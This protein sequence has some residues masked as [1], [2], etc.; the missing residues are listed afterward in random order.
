MLF[1]WSHPHLLLS[2]QPVKT[3]I[4]LC[5]NYFFTFHY[6]FT[7]YVAFS[8]QSSLFCLFLKHYI[9]ESRG[10]F[11]CVLFLSVLYVIYTKVHSFFLQWV[12][13]CMTASY[14]FYSFFLNLNLFIFIYL[15]FL[16]VL[17]LRFCVRAFSSCGEQGPLFIA[18]CGPLL[19]RSTGSRCAGSVAVAHGLSCSVACGIF[20]D[21]GSNR[22]P[23]HWQADSQPLRHQ[24][25]PILLLMDIW[26]IQ[27][28]CF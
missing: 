14:P 4:W 12:F 15:L 18:V 1:T 3:S 27:V 11:L 10:V 26:V 8:E 13:Y 21:Q 24:G 28:F 5:D 22:C 17:G 16:A 2:P 7:T 19:L 25:S 6:N 9:I 23:L 20:P